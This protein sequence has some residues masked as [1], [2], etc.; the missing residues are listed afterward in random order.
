MNILQKIK[1]LKE[2]QNKEEFNCITAKLP[3]NEVVCKDILKILN[4]GGVT[5]EKNNVENSTTS[6]YLVLNNKILLGNMKQSFTR[7]QTIAHECI[8]SIQNRNKLLFHYFLAN[9]IQ[10]WFVFSLILCIFVKQEVATWNIFASFVLAS[11]VLFFVRYSLEK[12]A[13]LRAKDLAKE[14][15]EQSKILSAEEITK[16]VAEYTEM[17]KIGIPMYRD[18]LIGQ[19]L[20]KIVVLLGMVLIFA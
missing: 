18:C 2:I 10:I 17:N 3:D 20:L 6:L 12:D 13:M 9:I 16:I 14:Y 19:M 15:M 4:N 1:Y 7:I 5:I 11:L 8:H